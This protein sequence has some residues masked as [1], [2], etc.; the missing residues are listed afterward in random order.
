MNDLVTTEI[1]SQLPSH[2]GFDDFLFRITFSK[3]K[4]DYNFQPSKVANRQA[5]MKNLLF[6]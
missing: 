4:I 3:P 5:V 6:D 2:F 1:K